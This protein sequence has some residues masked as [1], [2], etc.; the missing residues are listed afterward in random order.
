[1]PAGEARERNPE[2]TAE[3]IRPR[4]DDA[5]TIISGGA[6]I[7]SGTP[8]RRSPPPE[9]ANT[10]L[11]QIGTLLGSRYEILELLG[12]GGMGAVYKAADREVDRIVA[13]KVIRPEMAS[14]P[15]IL[16]RFKQELLLSSQVTHRNVIRIY[17]L[18]EA[19]GVKFITME[20]LEGENLHQIL[21]TRDKLEVAEAVDIMEQV[22]C[23]LA[24]AH[25]VGI[26]HRDLKPGNIMR[27][28]SGRVVVMDFGLA[29]TFSGDGMT[30]TG[31]ML[32][33]IEYMSPEQAQGMDVKASSD[34]FTVGLILYE[35][36][37]GVTPF[38]AE[39]AIASLLKRTQ[40]RAVPLADVDR[41]I[42]GTLSNI[43][44]KCLEKEPANRYQN[45]G[46]L[47]ADLCAWQGKGGRRVSASSARRRMNRIR[48]LPWP[49][50]AIAVVLIVAIAAGIA[51]YGIRRQQATK[52]MAHGPVSV[53]VGDFANHTG[54]PLLDNTIEP[55]LGVALEG[56]SFINSYSRGDARKL[57]KKLPN[58]TDKLDEQSARL[59][60]VN[61]GVNAVI[62]GDISLRDDQYDISAIALDA[63][64]GKVLAK[65]EISVANKQ[66]IVSSLPRLAAPIRKA[67][68]DTTPASVQFDEVS[69][70]FKA[71]SLE[72]VH[73]DA[74]G[75]DEQFAGKFQDA[76]DSF[77]KAS[78][79]DPKFARPYTGM[80]A[81]AQN[82]GRPGD[83]VKYMKLAMEHVDSMTE[84]ERYRN[85]ALYYLITGDW[86]NCAQEYTQ[87]VTHY[88]AD[89]V[90]QYNLATCYMQLRNVP[91]A[92]EAAQHAVAIVPRGVGPRLNLSFISSFDGDFAAGEKEA[93]AGL[94]LNP[95]SVQGY[96]VLAEAQVG[97][98]QID[99]ATESYRRLAD[100]G[101]AAASMANAGL[102]DLAAYQ[103]KYAEA[104]SILTN[105]AAADV[106][107]KNT[108]DAARK[109]AALGNIEELQGKHAAA[110]SDIGNALTYSQSTQIEFL[111]AST[112]VD[113]GEM[114]KAQK[115]AASLSS[116]LTSESQA[117]GKIVTGIMALKRK[118][119]N[120]AIRQITAANNLLDTWIGH[121]DLGQAYLEAGAFTEA[122]SQF[123]QCMKRRG[124][125][126][127]LFLDNT[128]T[129]TYFPPVYY[130]QGRV[131]EG[132]KSEGF[133]D[134]Y[135]SYLSLRGQSTEDPLVAEIRRRIGQ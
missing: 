128:P 28:K 102:A 99:N 54:D 85:R 44:A 64:S 25:A 50:L 57:A 105:G 32:G 119:S 23:G 78:Q 21:K 127:E 122:D 111:A 31:A 16:A 131:R 67:L 46:E 61:Q 87:L 42:P 37:A 72:A 13:L 10:I 125:A 90:G 88:P 76:F 86:Q 39:S 94:T 36:L 41:N 134:F 24:A 110:L 47:D 22:A 121:F 69:G 126:I 89:R 106:A 29:R 4:R 66:D 9:G 97:E 58:P 108:D 84:R 49:R 91:K 98:G 118:D 60:A 135:K 53:L 40:Q 101:P 79:L 115:L 113:A 1:V 7:V 65:S 8:G 2:A 133:A 52:L 120:E 45:A 33:T 93:R 81:M 26:I 83:A 73:E 35:L 30:Q 11:L 71:A 100:L 34:I 56:A 62:T 80:A 17:D 18:G 114:A 82:L 123:D 59:V 27:D 19:Q 5:A 38:Y 74:Q 14:N 132:M 43:V 116:A 51:W 20:Y 124:E 112:Y 77:Q 109:Y 6:T 95:S 104:A 48:E 96:L 68:G 12:E 15:E 55:M 107:A 75:V 117:Y 70:G 129:Y 103:G 130:Y 63:V 92:L 3:G